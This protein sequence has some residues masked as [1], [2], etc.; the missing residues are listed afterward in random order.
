MDGMG[1]IELRQFFQGIQDILRKDTEGL[2]FLQD[3]HHFLTFQFADRIAG[4][5]EDLLGL[6]D[7]GQITA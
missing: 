7:V 1:L 5:I 4:L 3:R 6:P 2:G